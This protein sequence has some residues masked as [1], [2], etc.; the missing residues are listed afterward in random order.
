[1]HLTCNVGWLWFKTWNPHPSSLF[2]LTHTHHPAVQVLTAGGTF[3]LFTGISACHFYFTYVTV[4]ETKG[5]TLEEIEAYL[6]KFATQP[7]QVRSAPPLPHARTKSSQASSPA[8]MRWARPRGALERAV[9]GVFD[10]AV[11]RCVRSCGTVV[12]QLGFH[13]WC[14]G[15][16]EALYTPSH[17][18]S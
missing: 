18:G 16:H 2:S 13:G 5:K 7:L 15:G 9:R 6:T 11:R 8:A 3:W 1:M 17:C 12:L 10:T 14:R 4:P